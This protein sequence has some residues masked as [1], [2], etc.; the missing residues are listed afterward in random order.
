VVYVLSISTNLSPWY[1][2]PP[3]DVLQEELL[4][5]YHIN[6]YYVRSNEINCIGKYLSV[7]KCLNDKISNRLYHDFVLLV[8]N[9]L[10]G[11][12][13]HQVLAV[14]KTYGL[15][16]FLTELN[17]FCLRTSCSYDLK[18]ITLR[19]RGSQVMNY[20][21]RYGSYRDHVRRA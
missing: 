6:Q 8:T 3:P 21:C 5:S 1:S 20:G 15:H 18:T 10:P 14:T 2:S 19:D 17:N 11:R 7:N 4:I 9:A 13:F 16:S 12:I